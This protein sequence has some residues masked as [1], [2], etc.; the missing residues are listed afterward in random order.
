MSLRII[1]N[2]KID[3]TN[4]E[5]V[6]YESICRSYDDINFKGSD[7]FCGLFETNDDGIII[8]LRPPSTKRTSFEVY[9]F[10]MTLLVHQHL[11]VIHSEVDDCCSQIKTKMAEIDEKLKKY[12]L[13][14]EE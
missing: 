10:L 8:F 1:D 11:R 2:K 4:E 6:L 7:L 5:W 13:I 3:M 9:L 14:Q 12:D